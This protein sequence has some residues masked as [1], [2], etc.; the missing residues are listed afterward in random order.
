[1]ASDCGCE[2]AHRYDPFVAR[3]LAPGRIYCWMGCFVQWHNA[4]NSQWE[5]NT[6]R[7]PA[8]C[9]ML[10]VGDYKKLSV[11]SYHLTA[12]TVTQ[13]FCSS[14]D[15]LRLVGTALLKE[16]SEITFFLTSNPLLFC[17]IHLLSYAVCLFVV[18]LFFLCPLQHSF[19]LCIEYHT[20]C[21]LVEILSLSKSNNASSL[22][23]KSRASIPPNTE[24]EKLHVPVKRTWA[25]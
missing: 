24:G 2:P 14:M 7:I 15:N 4:Y 20:R 6:A 16:V 22:A 25:N 18:M 11:S 13:P 17:L 5:S 19:S 21:C 1:M 23:I 3:C 8:V 9:E 10:A 12:V